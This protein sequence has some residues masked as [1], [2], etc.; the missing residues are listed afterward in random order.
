MKASAVFHRDFPRHL[1]HCAP[2]LKKKTVEIVFIKS[3][4]LL[5]KKY[6]ESLG[7]LD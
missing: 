7:L 3:G 1:I 2:E 4:K 5:L 6:F